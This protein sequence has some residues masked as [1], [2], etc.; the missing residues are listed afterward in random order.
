MKLDGIHHVSIN[1]SDVPAAQDFYVNVLGLELLD[2]P[3]FG[4]PG[5]WLRSGEQEVHLIGVDSGPPLKE[6]HFAFRVDSLDAVRS[7]LESAGYKCSKDNEIA[8]I[9]RQAFTRDPSGN[10]LEF[11]QRL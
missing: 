1:V 5:A 8:G 4:F 9:C 11:N 10:L 2:R 6:Q 3:D 7:T